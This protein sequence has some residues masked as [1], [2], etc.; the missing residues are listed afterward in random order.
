MKK[1]LLLYI[2]SENEIEKNQVIKT[3]CID[4]YLIKCKT[5][6]HVMT[7]INAAADNV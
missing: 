6:I 7:F 5:E 1:Q 4:F 2:K 3:L